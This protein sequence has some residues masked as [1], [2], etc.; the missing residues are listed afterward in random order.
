MMPIVLMSKAFELSTCTANAR[1]A[2]TA[3]RIRLTPSPMEPL[4]SPVE[5]SNGPFG[6]DRIRKGAS[7]RL[8]PR[9]QGF[10]H[11]AHCAGCR[12]RR[13]RDGGRSV[14]PLA[15]PRR[16]QGARRNR[17]RLLVHDRDLHRDL[18]A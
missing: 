11:P 13:G 16:L 12:F 10:A 1:T 17:S 9:A 15:P 2:P 14:H 18:R 3:M 5:R 6:Y 8:D 7:F 4:L